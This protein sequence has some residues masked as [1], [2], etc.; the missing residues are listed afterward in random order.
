MRRM[1]KQKI[2]K[3]GTGCANESDKEDGS[4][5][6]SVFERSPLSLIFLL[7]PGQG[8]HCGDHSATTDQ[9]TVAHPP[10]LGIKSFEFEFELG[11]VQVSF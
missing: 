10:W 4:T 11:R 6:E 9:S 3:S 1:Q 7:R 2:G 5:G 8:R